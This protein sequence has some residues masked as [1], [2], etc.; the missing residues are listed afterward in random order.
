MC[1]AILY[2]DH[3][4]NRSVGHLDSPGHPL[5]IETDIY[6]IRMRRVAGASCPDFKSEATAEDFTRFERASWSVGAK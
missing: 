2:L 1:A 5:R 4:N 6:K 3:P